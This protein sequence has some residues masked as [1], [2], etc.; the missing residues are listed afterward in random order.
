V[1]KLKYQSNR[2]LNVMSEKPEV[3]CSV[4]NYVDPGSHQ[5]GGA[6]SASLPAIPPNGLSEY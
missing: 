2:L 6:G 5:T 4:L 3:N 1:Q